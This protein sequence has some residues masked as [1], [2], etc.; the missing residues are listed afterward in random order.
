MYT[1]LEPEDPSS[2]TVSC[3][4]LSSRAMSRMTTSS[5]PEA[6]SLKSSRRPT[7]CVK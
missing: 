7:G 2:L 5:F 4:Y 1:T 3:R 6:N